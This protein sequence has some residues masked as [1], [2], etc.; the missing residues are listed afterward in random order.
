MLQGG[1]RSGENPRNVWWV[2]R[3]SGVHF[4]GFFPIFKDFF[5]WKITTFWPISTIFLHFCTKL[6]TLL[7]KENQI[8]CQFHIWEWDIEKSRSKFGGSSFSD[9]LDI[10]SRHS[11]K[12][13]V[14]LSQNYGEKL[15]GC[16]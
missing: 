4:L 5:S 3:V 1:G 2:G 16:R 10:D 12:V 14:R 6:C 8:R 7:L 9:Y 15:G 13:S 11:S